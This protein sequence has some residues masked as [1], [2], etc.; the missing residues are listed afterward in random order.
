MNGREELEKR[1]RGL[2][3]LRR[4]RAG[5]ILELAGS[6]AW[7]GDLGAMRGNSVV[8]ERSGVCRGGPARGAVPLVGGR[9]GSFSSGRGSRARG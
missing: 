3:A 1:V 2:E 5:R 4:A 7:H 6:G 8:R 9:A